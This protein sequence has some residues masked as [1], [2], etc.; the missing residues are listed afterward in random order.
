LSRHIDLDSHRNSKHLFYGLLAAMVLAIPVTRAPANEAAEVFAPGVVSAAGSNFAPTFPPSCSFVL[1]SRKS[2]G[3][4]SVL[5]SK[6][7]GSV[8]LDPIVAPFSGRWSDLETAISADGSYVVFASDRPIPS[9]NEPLRINNAGATQTGGNLWRVNIIGDEWSKPEWLPA[10]INK[11]S[12]TWT[13]SIASNGNLYFMSA[14]EKT[15]RFRLHLAPMSRGAYKST[16]D[17]IF[18]TGE[19][20][21]VDPMIDPKERFLIFS[22]DRGRPGTSISPGPERLF[23]AFKPRSLI[24]VVCP[25]KIPGWEDTS[26]SQVEA[27]LSNAGTTLYFASNHAVHKLNEA[28]AG[29]WDDGKTKIWMIHFNARL[30]GGGSAAHPVCN[31][32]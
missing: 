12:S 27:R 9:A 13:P 26:L 17:I 20:S 19:F 21:D 31:Q 30:W 1:F 16:R 11:G 14:D 25:I 28:P 2:N 18:S 29:S 7:N 23:I 6:R 4:I 32:K 10:S 5:L 3:G 22:S 15:G 8:W 24:P